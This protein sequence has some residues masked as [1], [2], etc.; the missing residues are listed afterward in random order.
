MI[1]ATEDLRVTL[2]EGTRRF[3]LVAEREGGMPWAMYV[4]LRVGFREHVCVGYGSTPAQ[5]CEAANA[6]AAAWRATFEVTN[7]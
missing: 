5:A 7:V 6:K 2:P 3:R 4:H 1:Y